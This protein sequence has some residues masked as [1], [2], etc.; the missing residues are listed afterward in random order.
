MIDELFLEFVVELL[1]LLPY[2]KFYYLGKSFY[3][4]FIFFYMLF[5]ISFNKLF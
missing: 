4:Y 3:H 5:N 1:L 2:F